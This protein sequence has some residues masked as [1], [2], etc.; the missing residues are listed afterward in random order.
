MGAF[1]IS[2]ELK[3]KLA[4]GRAAARERRKAA[5]G[6]DPKNS[7][8]LLGHAPIAEAPT[9][10]VAPAPEPV[11]E[12]EDE[13]FEQYVAQLDAETRTILNREEL[14]AIFFARTKKVT[15]TKRARALQIASEKAE[16][17]AKANA[18]LL[19]PAEVEKAKL[20]DRMNE[21]VSVTIDMPTF[22]DNGGIGDE[23]L[24]VDGKLYRH[25]ETYHVTRAVFM[26]LRK[27]QWDAQQAEL[28]FKGFG[29]LDHIRQRA[30]ALT[31]NI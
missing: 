29:R 23:G 9:I 2:D 5:M 10:E 26:T 13:G 17:Q 6:T 14:R 31:A 8:P 27:M 24:R 1:V 21:L 16:Q 19:T 11:V 12:A 3:A 15:E 30:S 4:A 7:G 22:G 25:G 20:R 28:S 18:G